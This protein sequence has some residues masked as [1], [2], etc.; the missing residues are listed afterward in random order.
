MQSTPSHTTTADKDYLSKL[1][2]KILHKIFLLLT[3]PPLGSSRTSPFLPV[4]C[5]S[6]HLAHVTVPLLYNSPYFRASTPYGRAPPRLDEGFENPTRQLL[7]RNSKARGCKVLDLVYRL[8]KDAIG[9]NNPDATNPDAK[10]EEIPALDYLAHIRYIDPTEFSTVFPE[11]QISPRIV[12]Y[13]KRLEE[14]EEEIIMG[15]E[16][17]QLPPGYMKRFQNK[18]DLVLRCFQVELYRQIIWHVAEP[19]LEQLRGLS[20]PLSDIDRYC[21]AVARFE[22][23]EQV[24]FILDEPFDFDSRHIAHRPMHPEWVSIRRERRGSHGKVQGQWTGEERKAEAMRKVVE[25]VREH[26]R[27]FRGRLTK[28][29]WKDGCFWPDALQSFPEDLQVEILASIPPTPKLKSL[30]H[31][32]WLLVKAH[33]DT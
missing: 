13:L 18:W 23:L 1:P 22:S 7:E 29:N 27:L 2:L 3:V 12:E 5:V 16:L 6:K 32:E 31:S 15:V 33:A 25:F 10:G 20:I 19:I 9:A 11:S 8:S 30:S 24:S 14:E 21:E 26:A 28:A 4:L 17:D